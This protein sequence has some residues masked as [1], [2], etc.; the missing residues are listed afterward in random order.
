MWLLF[1]ARRWLLVNFKEAGSGVNAAVFPERKMS[2]PI[3]TSQDLLHSPFL[4]HINLTD[5]HSTYSEQYANWVANAFPIMP[6]FCTIIAN[7][8]KALVLQP[9]VVAFWVKPKKK[10]KK[11]LRKINPQMINC[12]F[13]LALFQ[14]LVG[15]LATYCQLLFKAAKPK[16]ST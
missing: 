6:L 8:I 16:H 13:A 10:K 12:F 5:T 14:N 11:G 9:V 7:N 4:P 2:P 15:H 3:S 1:W